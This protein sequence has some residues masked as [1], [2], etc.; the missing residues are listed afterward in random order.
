[1]LQFRQLSF[2][3][4][5]INEGLVKTRLRKRFF[6]IVVMV[7]LV[8]ASSVVKHKRLQIQTWTQ[9][10]WKQL[11]PG[12]V[13]KGV[14]YPNI[15]SNGS[16]WVRLTLVFA[17]IGVS[18]ETLKSVARCRIA[19]RTEQK[20]YLGYSVRFSISPWTKRVETRNWTKAAA[21][22]QWFWWKRLRIIAVK[23]QSVRSSLKL[24]MSAIRLQV[25]RVD[26]WQDAKSGG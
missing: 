14:V 13:P 19:L 6:S 9:Y 4:R 21:N 5:S 15:Y 1:M 16:F 18:S 20:R 23:T 7:V 22:T 17:Q 25:L 24:K 26:S 12:T 8:S 11:R 10:G 2:L 3:G